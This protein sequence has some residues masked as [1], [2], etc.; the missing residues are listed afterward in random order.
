MRAY[1]LLSTALLLATPAAAQPAE[2]PLAKACPKLTPKQIA[3]IEN[4]KGQ[5]AENA[6]Y[7]RTYCVPV[8]EAERRMAIQLRDAIGP[9]TEPGRQPRPPADSIGAINATLQEREAATFAG[10]WIQNRGEYRV[11]VAFT[12]DA[13]ATLAKYTRDPLFK[14]IDRP[15]PS[16]AELRATQ[17]RLTTEFTKR[18]YRWSSASGQEDEGVVRIE[19]AQDAAPI[20][21]AAA[22]GEFALPSWVVLVE[23]RPL[24]VPAPPRPGPSDARVKSFPQFA[25]RTDMYP[26]TLVGVPDVPATLRLVDGCLVLQTDTDTRTAMWQASDA[27]DLSDPSRVTVLNRLSGVRVAAGDAIVLSGLQPGEEKV[28]KDVVGT[29]ACPGPYRVVQGFQ[30]RAAWDKGRREG[31][32]ASRIRDGHDR[33]AA[34]ADYEADQARLPALRAWRERMLTERGDAVAAIWIDDDQGTAHLFHTAARTR[35]QLA[36]A[37]LLPFVTGQVVPV[38][39]AVLEAARASLERQLAAAGVAADV[40]ASPIEGVVRLTPDDARALSAAA[41]AGRITFPA[42][43]R[44]AFNGA[45][46]FGAEERARTERD[47][48]AVW[49]RL[50]AAPDFAAVRK[51]VE[52]TPLPVSEH[53]Q[54]PSQS[55]SSTGDGR[56]EPPK[57]RPVR[58]ARPSRAA[59]LSS[60][61]FLVA[62]GQTARE[63]AALKARS[64]DPVEALDAM[65]GRATPVTNALLARQ[66]VVAELVGLDTRDRGKDGYRST[67]RWR[68]VETLKGDARAGDVLRMRMIS[69]EEADGR[70]AQSNE[71]PLVLPGLP[72]SLRPGGRWLLHLNDA[73]YA[74]AAFGHGGAGVARADGRWYIQTPVVPVSVVDGEARPMAS[75]QKPFPIADL[76][77]TL[78]PLQSAFVAIGPDRGAAR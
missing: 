9:K 63:I 36:P 13:A 38:G 3:A 53:P 58:Y 59:S 72:G 39:H 60:A 32:I 1:L 35:E 10:L 43:T 77:R 30:P 56:R 2:A 7:A 52:E 74:H 75:E 71:E 50:E 40:Q 78:A 29:E 8:E 67:A 44:I 25:F 17:D 11:V 27:L 15:G 20:R 28:P 6:L 57:P 16:L 24:P 22:R 55:R 62:Y 21:A 33:A 46:P 4:Y 54:P 31:R 12:R 76:R 42:V 49:L 19:L 51:L 18:G 70:I 14:P 61:Q 69:G 45:A 64:F 23:P 37:S 41:V 65:N 5:F 68:V 73:L 26:S 34:T 66:V 47:P 48:E